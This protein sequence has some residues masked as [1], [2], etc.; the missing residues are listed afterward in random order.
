MII[1]KVLIK[2]LSHIACFLPNLCAKIFKGLVKRVVEKK[3]IDR[4]A[5]A[6]TS[7]DVIL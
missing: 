1:L 3:A 2:Q 7:D 4:I 5:V 6:M